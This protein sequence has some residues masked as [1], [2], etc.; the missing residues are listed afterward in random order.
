ML[1]DKT[2][3]SP[4]ARG[5]AGSAQNLNGWEHDRTLATATATA[6]QRAA[7]RRAA[8]GDDRLSRLPRLA[9]V[10][11]AGHR[12]PRARLRQSRGRARLAEEPLHVPDPHLLDRAALLGGLAAALLRPD[13]LRADLR[14]ARLADRA[15]RARPRSAVEAR[16]LSQPRELDH[17]SPAALNAPAWRS[18]SAGSE[19]PSS[20]A[21]K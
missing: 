11:A 10:S 19:K 20:V 3:G 17:L 2:P 8:A 21:S 9:G 6:A 7:E 18:A 16:G 14:D 12:R 4:L 13:R 15:L 1:F 5:R